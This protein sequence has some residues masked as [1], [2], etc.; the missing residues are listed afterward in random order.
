M[1]KLQVFDPALCCSTGVCGVDVDQAL[2]GFA[3]DVDW[4]KQN[5]AQI[6][7]FNLAQQPLAFA[8]NATVKAF[9]E[10][11]GQEGLPLFLVDDAVVLSGRYPSRDE[12]IKWLGLTPTPSL[13]TEQVA[14]LV[15]IGAA[16]GANC[17]P[18]FKYHYDQAR[19]LGV[20]DLDMRYA[21]DLAQKVKDTPARAML[22]LAER[23]LGPATASTTT[24]A[25]SCCV[26]E[27][28]AGG[29]ASSKCCG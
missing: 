1:K 23:Y 18:C 7:R 27:P 17:E 20:S 13:F 14:E 9:L 16:I 6:E 25:S 8:E 10:S 24:K 29:K 4:A 21:V 28:V 11:A 22:N 15:A 5:G 2:V 26:T 12:L 3:A 19:K